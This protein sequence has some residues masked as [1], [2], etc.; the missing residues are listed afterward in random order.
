MTETADEEIAKALAADVNAGFGPMYE[1]HRGVVY[2]TALRVTGSGPEAEDLTAE[3]FLRAFRALA[4]YDAAKIE[5]LDLRPWLLTILL[6]AWRNQLRSAS[7]RPREVLAADPS[8]E[9]LTPPR[10]AE[11][12]PAQLAVQHEGE[13]ELAAQLRQLPQTQRVAVVLRHV[14]ELP[15]G[16]VAAILGC[17][18][19]TAKS[20][21]S[22]GL[23]KLRAQYQPAHPVEQAP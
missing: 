15:I 5:S 20:H 1:A 16:Q 11:P 8:A 14:A 19:G 9:G 12:G 17:P 18:E 10:A 23:R 21:V 7:R 6:N 3:A 2:S 13:R 22:R 4:G